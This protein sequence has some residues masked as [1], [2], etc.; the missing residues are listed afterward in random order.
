MFRTPLVVELNGAG[1]QRSTNKVYS[2]RWPRISKFLGREMN[3]AVTL[4]QME[5]IGEK[6]MQI[7]N[8]EEDSYELE[9]QG[10]KVS[11]N[12]EILGWIQKLERADGVEE[13]KL[14]QLYHPDEPLRTFDATPSFPFTPPLSFDSSSMPV[15]SFV[16]PPTPGPSSERDALLGNDDL[17]FQSTLLADARVQADR[18]KPDIVISDSSSPCRMTF[19]KRRERTKSAEEVLVEAANELPTPDPSS[20]DVV[21]LASL[22]AASEPSCAIAKPTS[23]SKK[24][25]RHSSLISKEEILQKR[26]PALRTILGRQ[27]SLPVIPSTPTA[28]PVRRPPLFWTVFPSSFDNEFFATRSTTAPDY[29]KLNYCASFTDVC[30]EAGWKGKEEDFHLQSARPGRI[31][32]KTQLEVDMLWELIRR[33]F[34]LP[35][36]FMAGIVAD[37]E[38]WKLEGMEKGKKGKHFRWS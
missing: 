29:N 1:F 18:R 28:T 21:V 13:S 25:C 6:A 36:R 16:I 37:V 24:I 26:S 17:H 35:M 34:E 33:N 7:D 8:G 14:S 3:D 11:R 23:A 32:V 4:S 22:S 27:N 30:R 19:R 2:L 5:D 15:A 10:K 31:F 20:D 38:V 12:E 9:K